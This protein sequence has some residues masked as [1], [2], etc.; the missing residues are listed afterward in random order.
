METLEEKNYQ[1][2]KRSNKK[3]HAQR[4]IKTKYAQSVQI[5]SHNKQLYIHHRIAKKVNLDPP[6]ENYLPSPPSAPL[7]SPEVL[8]SIF[9]QCYWVP[10]TIE[11]I[12]KRQPPP[13]PPASNTHHLFP[14][15]IINEHNIQ[16]Q[17]SFDDAMIA[18]LFDM[19]NRDL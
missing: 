4:Q 17:Q 10:S 19:Q 13:A 8:R 12:K 9:R 2:S 11:T 16:N 14:D 1:R 5:K 15:Y 3:M 7:Y 18:F 6:K